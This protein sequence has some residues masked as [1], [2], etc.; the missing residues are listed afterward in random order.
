MC[1]SLRSILQHVWQHGHEQGCAAWGH[2]RPHPPGPG[3]PA[4]WGPLWTH[5]WAQHWVHHPLPTTDVPP[6]C[7]YKL[8]GCTGT[9][10]CFVANLGS[11][12]SLPMQ[13]HAHSPILLCIRG[14]SSS[15][16][17][18]LTVCCCSHHWEEPWVRQTLYGARHCC[19]RLLRHKTFVAGPV[20]NEQAVSF[21]VPGWAMLR[22]PC[23]QT[24]VGVIRQ[25]SV[26]SK[27]CMCKQG[28]GQRSTHPHPPACPRQL[29]LPGRGRPQATRCTSRRPQKPCGPLQRPTWLLLPMERACSCWKPGR[30]VSWAPNLSKQVRAHPSMAFTLAGAM[31]IILHCVMVS[32]AACARTYI[33]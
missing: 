12:A 14:V 1:C 28:T 4:H 13:P 16:E 8:H 2:F 19:L 27:T 23:H 32:S 25:T 29:A 6:R 7:M 15:L 18:T 31:G 26:I 24:D 30:A 10:W 9:M 5:L 11:A 22:N 21:S 33:Y 20:G 3:P 17:H